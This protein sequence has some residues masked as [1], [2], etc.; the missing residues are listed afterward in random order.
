VDSPAVGL[1]E[2]TVRLPSD[3]PSTTS[4][5]TGLSPQTV[6]ACCFLTRRDSKVQELYRR[7]QC[8]RGT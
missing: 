3:I 4:A 6:Y 8:A 7:V 2:A 1:C 5:Q